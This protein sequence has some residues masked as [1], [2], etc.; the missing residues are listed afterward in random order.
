M[1]Q[2][3]FGDGRTFVSVLEEARK[4]QPLGYVRSQGYSDIY[5]MCEDEPNHERLP[6]VKRQSENRQADGARSWTAMGTNALGDKTMEVLDM[7]NFR[8]Q[9]TSRA[10]LDQWREKQKPTR[11]YGSPYPWL[12]RF[13][14]AFRVSYGLG[15]WQYGYDG[16]FDFAYQWHGPQP[17]DFF[18]IDT[19]GGYQLGYTLP[20][21]GKPVPTLKWECLREANDDLRYLSTLL[22]RI[23]AHLAQNAEDEK[24]KAAAA[25]IEEMKTMQLV[26]DQR[27]LQGIRLKMVELILGLDQ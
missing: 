18:T 25:F 6:S 17:W 27:D 24:A 22:D 12:H 14:H 3:G 4:P 21:V 10:L 20:T 26:S 8:T 16:A 19:P 2:A 23:D 13:A 1:K 9:F 5:L 11:V 7:A 15:M